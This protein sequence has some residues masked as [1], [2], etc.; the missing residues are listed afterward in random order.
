MYYEYI[1]IIILISLSAQGFNILMLSN[2]HALLTLWEEVYKDKGL[3][4]KLF[5]SLGLYRI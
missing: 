3:Y 5:Y 1:L 2:I 4:V